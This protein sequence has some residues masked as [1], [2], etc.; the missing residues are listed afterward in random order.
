MN[1]TPSAVQIVNELKAYTELKDKQIITSEQ[2]KSVK[3]LCK[4][5][6]TMCLNVQVGHWNQMISKMEE[7]KKSIAVPAEEKKDAS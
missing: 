6:A 7:A 3:A 1:E 4:E 2:L 5:M